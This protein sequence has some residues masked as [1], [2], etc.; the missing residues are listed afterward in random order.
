VEMLRLYMVRGRRTSIAWLFDID[1]YV[2]IFIPDVESR[3]GVWKRA[4][5]FMALIVISTLECISID[6]LHT[7]GE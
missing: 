7:G 4:C 6:T 3:W 1:Q 2:H 5:Y